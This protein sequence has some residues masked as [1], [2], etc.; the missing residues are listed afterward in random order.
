MKSFGYIHTQPIRIKTEVPSFQVTP[1]FPPTD[2]PLS[3]ELGEEAL[4]RRG[5][6]HS[7]LHLS[8]VYPALHR[9]GDAG[10]RVG[11]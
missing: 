8:Q 6:C 7:G 2:H 4:E 3:P 1:S 11:K 9:L 5:E 10:L